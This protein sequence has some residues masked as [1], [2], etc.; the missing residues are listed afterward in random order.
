MN[1]NE[2]SPATCPYNWTIYG[3]SKHHLFMP[4]V[5]WLAVKLEWIRV[6]DVVCWDL[7]IVIV[8]WML[9]YDNYVACWSHTHNHT[10]VTFALRFGH[11]SIKQ[12]GLCVFS[13]ASSL[14]MIVRVCVLLLLIIIRPDI[15]I[16][17]H[18]LGFRH[19]TMVCV[20]CLTIIL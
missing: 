6:N 10:Q 19:E 15:C 11:G 4:A 20:V 9:M 5:D 7:V 18:Y 16:I 8:M 2:L 13:L 1:L 14:V 17:S 12:M 3:A